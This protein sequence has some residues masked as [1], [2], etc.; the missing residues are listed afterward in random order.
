M[1][2]IR[3]NSHRRGSTRRSDAKSSLR[4]IRKVI[5]IGGVV[6]LLGGGAI[7][8]YGAVT[9]SGFGLA[10]NTT[11]SQTVSA[12]AA[13]KPLA[14]MKPRVDIEFFRA[15]VSPGDAT[16]LR[17]KTDPGIN[18][19]IKIIYGKAKTVAAVP[20]PEPKKTGDD[21]TV[22]WKWT[23]P[24]SMP[25]GKWSTTVTCGDENNPGQASKI[26]TVSPVRSPA[27]TN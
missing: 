8:G 14:G 23:V 2:E 27:S 20:G 16:T 10:M 5:V 6:A 7:F 11:Y 18:C 3:K 1:L 21:G 26:L 22:T 12:D 9:G 24:S 4:T 13:A 25:I 19:T 15:Q 17:A